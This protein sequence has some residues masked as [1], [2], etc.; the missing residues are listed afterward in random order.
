MH[1]NQQSYKV[2]SNTEMNTHIHKTGTSVGQSAQWKENNSV[3]SDK[4]SQE[5]SKMSAS[6]I[7]EV[8]EGGHQER[9]NYRGSHR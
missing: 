9:S 1:Y 8:F 4:S 7:D 2:F 5:H 6:E 3:D